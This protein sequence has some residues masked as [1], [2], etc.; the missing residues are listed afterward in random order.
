MGRLYSAQNT[1]GL[2][3]EVHR[4]MGYRWNFPRPRVERVLWRPDTPERPTPHSSTERVR[5]RHPILGVDL[6]GTVETV[7]PDWLTGDSSGTTAEISPRG[8]ERNV[9]SCASRV[10]SSSQGSSVDGED[11]LALVMPGTEMPKGVARLAES[12]RAVDDRHQLAGFE[13]LVQVR[14]VP[15]LSQTNESHGLV[16]GHANPP[17]NDGHP[18]QSC[19]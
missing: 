15:V 18:Q 12:I 13:A 10:R 6:A 3:R 5:P 14:Q 4:R 8:E 7:G 2:A 19:D 1:R 11:D 16:C 9:I 17:A